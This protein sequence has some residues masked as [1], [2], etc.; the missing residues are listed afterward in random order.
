MTLF[1]LTK[2]EERYALYVLTLSGAPA[3]VHASTASLWQA[4]PTN[5]P[6]VTQPAGLLLLPRGQPDTEWSRGGRC[7]RWSDL[8][9]QPPRTRPQTCH[10]PTVMDHFF[11]KQWLQ[12]LFLKLW[13]FFF[14]WMQN[15]VLKQKIKELVGLMWKCTL[16]VGLQSA[17]SA[18]ALSSS[19]PSREMPKST[20]GLQSGTESR[21]W[22]PCTSSGIT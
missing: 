18:S 1:F 3:E 5:S 20:L 6:P 11:Q 7:P 17:S 9:E 21:A 13:I 10:L 2:A 15:T 14:Q 19:K 22:G 16:G 4:D 8:R 12:S